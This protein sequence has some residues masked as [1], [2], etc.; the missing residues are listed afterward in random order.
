MWESTTKYFSP[1]FSYMEEHLSRGLRE[2]SGTASRHENGSAADLA[3]LE[4]G[5]GGDG[6]VQWVLLRVQSDPACLSEHHEVGQAGV[7]ADGVADDV[8]FRG[9]DGQRPDAQLAAAGG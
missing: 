2:I 5:Q 3:G 1:F 4:A 9:D 7:G 8:P 6:L